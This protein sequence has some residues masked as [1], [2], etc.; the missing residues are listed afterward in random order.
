MN[1]RGFIV[2]AFL[3]AAI[4]F[5]AHADCFTVAANTQHVPEDILRA[6]AKV[7]SNFNPEALN[8]TSHALGVMQII[9]AN[10]K[11]LLKYNITEPD[12]HQACT[13]INAGAWLLAGFFNQ[14]GRVWRAV[15]AYGVGNGKS[16]EVEAQRVIYA[17]KVQQ[18]LYALQRQGHTEL[19]VN[20]P[21]LR[22]VMVVME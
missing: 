11:S 7:E 9:P 3:F 4:N 12:L 1:L 20:K 10:F 16:R 15:G 6:I 17:G 2:T 8:P 18:A 19:I 14:Y 13:N 21:S 22:P 5:P